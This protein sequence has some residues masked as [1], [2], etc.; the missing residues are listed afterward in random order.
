M[1][2]INPIAAVI[3]LI[4]RDDDMICEGLAL[5]LPHHSCPYPSLI[6]VDNIASHLGLTFS[7]VVPCPLSSPSRSLVH[8]L[9]EKQA[10]MRQGQA[11]DTPRG[12]S[13]TRQAAFHVDHAPRP[14]L[15]CRAVQ[16]LPLPAGGSWGGDPTSNH[17]QAAPDPAPPSENMCCP[18]Q[19]IETCNHLGTYVEA[20]HA[21][22]LIIACSKKMKA[23][24][25]CDANC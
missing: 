17:R 15:R 13:W 1:P 12:W 11:G 5:I 18:S 14:W 21:E 4:L 19:Q 2:W 20:Q 9:L 6:S 23:N 16:P 3:G 10:F 24:P 7:A 22:V 25:P 8:L